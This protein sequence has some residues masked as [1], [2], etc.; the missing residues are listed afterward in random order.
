MTTSPVV[1]EI[2]EAFRDA[3]QEDSSLSEA[4]RIAVTTA[5]VDGTIGTTKAIQHIRQIAR[6][7]PCHAQH[8]SK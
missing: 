8:R 7:E 3:V 1:T 2:L 4:V 6:S 5:I